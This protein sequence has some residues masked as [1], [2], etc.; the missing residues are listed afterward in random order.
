[1]RTKQTILL[2]LS[3]FFF[4]EL[5]FAESPFVATVEGIKLEYVL[6][7]K[8]DKITG[9]LLR[10]VQNKTET[11]DGT[12]VITRA[13]TLD[14]DRKPKKK[15]PVVISK[16]LITKDKVIVLKESLKSSLGDLSTK[17][18]I[19]F[20]GDDILYPANP[21]VGQTLEP[22]TIEMYVK[23]DEGEKNKR[24]MTIFSEERI[25]NGKENITV[26]AVTYDCFKVL[27]TVKVKA[28]LGIGAT[29]YNASW[30]A[31]GI[32]EVMSQE[33]SKKGKVESTTKLLS[34]TYP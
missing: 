12:L 1:M 23:T 17:A 5:L 13:E 31:A 21:M 18:D 7:D 30:Y 29:T 2:I 3:L 22:F 15:M 27:E 6:L 33:L 28:L 32:G 20:E 19:L 9:Y 34:V 26:N 16:V 14:K 10:T 4:A 24:L 8:N 25:I 11:A